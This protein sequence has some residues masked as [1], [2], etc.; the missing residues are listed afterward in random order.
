MAELMKTFWSLVF[1]AL[2]SAC[3]GQGAGRGIV[4]DAGPGV[5]VDAS[6]GPVP[7]GIDFAPYFPSWAWEGGFAFNSLVDLQ[8]KSGVD[9]VTLAFVLAGTGCKTDNAIASHLDDI[10]AFVQG[11]GHVKASFGGASGTYLESRCP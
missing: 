5:P 8:D 10:K 1:V 6:A 9:E 11:G 2:G 4:A 3:A 7:G